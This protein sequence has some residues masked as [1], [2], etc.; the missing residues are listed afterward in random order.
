MPAL[1]ACFKTIDDTGVAIGVHVLKKTSGVC[2][3]GAVIVAW[4]GLVV[5]WAW[6]A[7]ECI[8]DSK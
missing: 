1:A 8:L 4:C 2:V 3:D 5:N 7:L 6:N